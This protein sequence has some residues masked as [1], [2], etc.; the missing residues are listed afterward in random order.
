MPVAVN[1]SE[2]VKDF[3]SDCPWPLSLSL[4]SVPGNDHGRGLR[5][6]WDLPFADL[7]QACGRVLL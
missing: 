7:L 4:A 3:E 5:M 1:L 6:L 2:L